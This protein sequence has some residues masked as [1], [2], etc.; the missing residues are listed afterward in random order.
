MPSVKEHMQEV[1]EGEGIGDWMMVADEV[2]RYV[3]VAEP[4]EVEA[5]E[6]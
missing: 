5:I 6:H 2:D 4:S 1:L 3:L